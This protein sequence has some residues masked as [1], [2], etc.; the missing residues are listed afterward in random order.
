V[1]IDPVYFGEEAEPG[2]GRIDADRDRVEIYLITKSLKKTYL[3]LVSAVVY[4]YL[5]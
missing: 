1:D 3:Y 2:L 5:M 4:K